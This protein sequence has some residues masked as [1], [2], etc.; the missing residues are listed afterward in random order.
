[1][2]SEDAHRYR[3]RTI[4]IRSPEP[5]RPD[6]IHQCVGRCRRQESATIMP[7]A[8]VENPGNGSQQ[9]VSPT[10]GQRLV[11]MGKPKDRGGYEQRARVTDTW[12]EQ[13]LEQTAKEQLF[14]NGNE[15]ERD[16][17][18]SRHR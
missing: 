17:Q 4:Q 10:E 15:E 13:I 1:M 11:E 12:L 2:K 7:C 5:Q 8:T 18:R 9:H 6:Y 14:W 16:K 3:R